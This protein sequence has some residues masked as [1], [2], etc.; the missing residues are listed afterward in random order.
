MKLK[1]AQAKIEELEKRIAA[2][3]QRPVFVPV[4]AY[5]QPI[6]DVSPYLRPIPSPFY[7]GPTCIGEPVIT[8]LCVRN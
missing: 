8:N 6:W 4:P 3:E 7:E 5:P 1:E 2:L